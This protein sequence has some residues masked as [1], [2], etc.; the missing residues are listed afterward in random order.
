[1]LMFIVFL[2]LC[3]CNTNNSST[4]IISVDRETKIPETAQKITVETD[5]LPPKSHSIEYNDPIPLP[6][7]VNTAGA[8]DSAFILPNG[9]TL[10]FWFTPD[11]NVLPEKQ[12]LD[13][14]TGI[15][16]SEKSREQWSEP[17]RVL[18]QDSNKLSLDGAQFIM[19]NEMWFCSAR[20]GFQG[21]EY[22]GGLNWFTA[23][24][25]LETNLWK[26]WSI[27]DFPEEF[28]VGE[29]HIHSNEL[30]FHSSRPGGRGGL[31][32]WVMTLD[33]EGN[34][35]NPKNVKNVNTNRD[36]GF[37]ALSPDG[38]ELWI[39]R[40]FGLWRSKRID[41]E[42]SE[43]ELMFSPLAG[44]ASIDEYDNVYFTHHYL[45]DNR[46]VEADIF[47]AHKKGK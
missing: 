47:V 45:L 19:G 9:E 14:V 1:M 44:E 27:V 37:P 41:G 39:S 43:P 21:K 16:M 22:S 3:G 31:D 46:M 4:R 11:V 20:E 23:R 29:L 8:E 12:I 7:P 32:I 13:E 33:S 2:V 5:E 17:V 40:D 6:Y 15:Y 28:E 36:D 26:D 10:Y 35:K 34:W 24:F 30:Y 18:L 25:N 38:K 42:W